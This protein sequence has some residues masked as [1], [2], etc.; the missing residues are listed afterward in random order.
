MR[1]VV[2]AKYGPP[3]VL[4][5]ADVERPIPAD[6]EVLVRVNATTVNRFDTATR[7]A[8]R[9]SGLTISLMSRLVSGLRRPRHRILGTEF[10]GVVEAAG[11][12][13]SEFAVGDKVF[14]TTGLSFGAHAEY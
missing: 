12:A 13:V 10:A 9:R 5:L 7:E 11:G 4:R 2:Y 14:G 8:N 3:D 1:A 6:N